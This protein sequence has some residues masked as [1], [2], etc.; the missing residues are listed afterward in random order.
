MKRHCRDAAGFIERFGP[1]FDTFISDRAYYNAVTMCLLQIGE[2]ANGLSED[3]RLETGREM[4]W[5]KIRGMRN[6]LAHNYSNADEETV[7]KTAL[8]DLPALAAFC[9]RYLESE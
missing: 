6:L 2:L 9:A 8:H 4:P 7:W 1:D 3:F 5:N